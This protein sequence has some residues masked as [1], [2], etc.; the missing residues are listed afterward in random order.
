M[1]VSFTRRAVADLEEIAAYLHERSPYGATRV[2][3][4]I[5]HTLENLARFPR[6]GRSQ[7]VE[8]VRKFGTPRYPY[9]IY[10]TID[11]LNDQ[12]VV[13]SIRHSA[14]RSEMEDDE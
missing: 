14:R 4:A 7:A 10:Y 6:L 5:L 9:L 11:E 1:N 3:S 2:R 12:I 13:L 8:G